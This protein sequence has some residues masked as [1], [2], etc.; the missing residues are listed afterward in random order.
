MKW[1]RVDD[2]A[3]GRRTSKKDGPEWANVTRRVTK[4]IDTGE[5]LEDISINCTPTDKE[6][7]R[8]FDDGSKRNIITELYYTDVCDVAYANWM[9]E[10][11]ETE[12]SNKWLERNDTKPGRKRKR[13]SFS[14]RRRAALRKELIFDS[15][16]PEMQAKLLVKR[17]EEWNAWKQFNAADV[18]VGPERD[19]I[20]AEGHQLLPLKMGRGREERN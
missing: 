11:V 16:T 5:T 15:C 19:A 18:L 1:T 2:N 6:L 17:E 13:N 4:D 8:C 20:L 9:A 3:K 14:T 10:R 12:D 7:N